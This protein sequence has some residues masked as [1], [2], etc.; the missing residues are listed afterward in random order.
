MSTVLR[1]IL[2]RLRKGLRYRA[3]D[4]PII[5]FVAIINLF[6]WFS[7]PTNVILSILTLVALVFSYRA[8]KRNNMN[9]SPHGTFEEIIYK[10]FSEEKHAIEFMDGR[11]RFTRIDIYTT[12]ENEK[13][14][15][16]T[17]GQG[18]VV[19]NGIK[20]HSQRPTKG[21]YIC[22]FHRCLK[23]AEKLKHP[24]VVK[25]P[26][27]KKIAGDICK[28][29]D[30]KTSSFWGGVEG[31]PVEYDKGEI[32]ENN[33]SPDFPM[34]ITYSQKPKIFQEENEFRFV[35]IGKK[36]LGENYTFDLQ[37][38]ISGC[39]LIQMKNKT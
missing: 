36:D 9:I 1:I 12:I 18:L 4:Y 38:R 31:V 32:R 28:T 20:T 11:I 5:C 34:Y 29:L 15:D 37:A 33:M 17:E 7:Y 3:Y 13:L 8:W 16:A 25:F 2:K 22:C 21:T 6:V 35:I 19:V 23:S 27:P 10:G 26:N 30:K 39:K 14:R 24:Y